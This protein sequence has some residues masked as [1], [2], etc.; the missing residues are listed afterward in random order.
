M[1]SVCKERKIVN[2]G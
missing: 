1:Y 2:I